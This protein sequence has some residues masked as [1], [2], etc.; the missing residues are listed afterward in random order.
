M[1]KNIQ[2]RLLN[3][4]GACTSHTTWP[5][6]SSLHCIDTKSYSGRLWRSWRLLGY[7]WSSPHHRTQH[8]SHPQALTSNHKPDW[9]SNFGSDSW[10]LE[11]CFWDFPI[12]KASSPQNNLCVSFLHFLKKYAIVFFVC[13]LITPCCAQLCPSS[14]LRGHCWQA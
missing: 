10:V 2:N 1:I 3:S 5:R 12:K 6:F 11:H 7:F 14:A 8:H 9:P 13:V 4:L